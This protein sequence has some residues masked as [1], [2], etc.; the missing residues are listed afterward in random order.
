MTILS[1]SI[2]ILALGAQIILRFFSCMRVARLRLWLRQCESAH[3]NIYKYIFYFSIIAVFSFLIFYSYKQYV[4]WQAV[5]PAKFLLPPHQ[6]IDYFI[7]Y[8]GDRFFAPY[9]VS[10]AAA[11]VFLFVAKNLNKKYKERFFEPEE[12]WLGTLAIFFV[13]HPGWLF[14]FT[15]LILIYL[16]IHIFITLYYKLFFRVSP[17]EVRVS[18]RF[19]W[20]PLAIFVV[21]INKWLVGLGVW[22][23]LKI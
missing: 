1:L 6:S 17:H 2:L 3:A 18:L 21:I 16:F 20:L 14:Y 12:L 4:V 10:F 15:G 5:E 9:L 11:L 23:L 7:K 13:G 19:W 22:K 8:V